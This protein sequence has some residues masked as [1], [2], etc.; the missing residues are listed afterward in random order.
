MENCTNSHFIVDLSYLGKN[1]TDVP[2][3]VGYLCMVVSSAFYGLNYIPVKKFETGD[4]MF[5]QLVVSIGKSPTFGP[6]SL[7]DAIVNNESC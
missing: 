7:K 5:F 1:G 4:G 3:F 2:A 6:C